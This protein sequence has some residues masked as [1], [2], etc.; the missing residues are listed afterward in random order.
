[1]IP[2]EFKDHDCPIRKEQGREP[3]EE[4]CDKCKFSEIVVVNSDSA[5]GKLA[6][7]FHVTLH[8]WINGD[9][10]S[11]KKVREIMDSD[12][13][14]TSV[15]WMEIKFALAN[16]GLMMAKKMLGVD[17][18][19]FLMTAFTMGWWFA[20]EYKGEYT[21]KLTPSG[22]IKLELSESISK[23]LDEVVNKD[24]SPQG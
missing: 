18:L 2:D 19:D 3:T 10:E 9:S 14:W 11:A 13:V 21:N 12:Q 15:L 5:G 20:H 17:I 16:P 4:E 23:F 24:D 1:M 6:Q 7:T 22:D 8:E